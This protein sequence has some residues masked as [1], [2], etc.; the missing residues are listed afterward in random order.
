MVVSGLLVVECIDGADWEAAVKA[1]FLVVLALILGFAYLSSQT[2]IRQSSIPGGASRP[3]VAA[4][5]SADGI[6]GSEVPT[7]CPLVLSVEVGT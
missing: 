2:Q 5:M 7:N 4:A 1:S 6:A 3:M